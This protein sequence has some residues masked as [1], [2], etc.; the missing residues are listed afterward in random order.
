MCNEE[1]KGEGGA[2]LLP[3]EYQAHIQNTVFLF[4]LYDSIVSKQGIL[5]PRFQ[6]IL[7]NTPIFF[8]TTCTFVNNLGKKMFCGLDIAYFTVV[9]QGTVWKR[10]VRYLLASPDVLIS[11]KPERLSRW[12]GGSRNYP[13]YKSHYKLF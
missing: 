1:Y 10:V 4:K 8:R 6:D 11:I 2:D 7:D 9:S 13:M 12:E 5:I 3:T